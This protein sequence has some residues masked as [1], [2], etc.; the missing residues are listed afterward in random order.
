MARPPIEYR[1]KLAKFDDAPAHG[2]TVDAGDLKSPEEIRGGSSPS[3]PT[4]SSLDDIAG[5]NMEPLTGEALER[6]KDRCEVI[7]AR[8]LSKPTFDRNE[9]Q[10]EYMRDLPKAKAE[11]LTVKA[12]RDKHGKDKNND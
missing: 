11:G 2:G 10:R 1:P 7:A 4:I 12:W 9:Y 8:L 3:V 6:L 5:L